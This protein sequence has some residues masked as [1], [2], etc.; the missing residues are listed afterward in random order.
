MK[1][2]DKKVTLT[3]HQGIGSSG[4]QHLTYIDKQ[5]IITPT[6]YA[7]LLETKNGAIT[8]D[9]IYL[10]EVIISIDTISTEIC[11]K[12][13][14]F[15]LVD[16]EVKNKLNGLTQDYYD[17]FVAKEYEP[18]FMELDSFLSLREN[19]DLQGK[20]SNI[21]KTLNQKIHI[22]RNKYDTFESMLNDI[23]LS[24]LD[25]QYEH[26]HNKVNTVQFVLYYLY[27]SCYIGK[28]TKSENKK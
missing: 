27:A 12:P 9:P 26:L 17:T 22:S 23:E 1:K 19:E 11:A 14:D 21:I 18:Y 4:E 16:I 5:E 10:R 25:S 13:T 24:L 28:K 8:F 3:Q 6:S 15:S 7:N 20:I 2:S